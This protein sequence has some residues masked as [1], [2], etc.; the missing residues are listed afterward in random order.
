ML[1]AQLSPVLNPP[2]R[3]YQRD[4]KPRPAREA[5]TPGN[6]KLGKYIG[7][8]QDVFMTVKLRAV[9]APRRRLTGDAKLLESQF[10]YD[11]AASVVAVEVPDADRPCAEVAERVTNA[12]FAASVAMP[13]PAYF[14]ATQ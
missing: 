12:A 11:A 14:G 1:P 10:L 9:E 7:A 8:G 13:C 5:S 4:Q 6:V 3:R 2:Y